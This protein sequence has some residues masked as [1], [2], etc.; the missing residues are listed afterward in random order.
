LGAKVG[1]TVGIAQNFNSRGEPRELNRS[2]EAG[3]ARAIALVEPRRAP[4][5]QDQEE[6]KS[7]K[8]ETL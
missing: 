2:I 4:H 1:N 7:Q 3:K 8:G 6:G 5:D